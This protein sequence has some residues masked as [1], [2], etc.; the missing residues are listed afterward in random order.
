[1]ASAWEHGSVRTSAVN[2]LEINGANRHARTLEAMR[3]Q[4]YFHYSRVSTTK[5]SLKT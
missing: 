5:S 1:M 3:T 2:R 4:A